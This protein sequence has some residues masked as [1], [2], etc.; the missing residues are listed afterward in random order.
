MN[1]VMFKSKLHRA[2]I[3]HADLYYEGSLTI[4]EALMK[5]A[6][7]LPYEKVS[8]VNINNGERFETYVIPGKSGSRDVG[9]NGAAARKGQVG[10]EVII[11]SYT[12]VSDEE[13]RTIRPTVVLLDK[14]NNIVSTSDSVEAYTYL[15]R[16]N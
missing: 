4:D 13:A 8:V 12:T 10:D 9:L 14:D 11:I 1:R 16:D 2:R 15:G 3:T 7:L 5:A 6:D